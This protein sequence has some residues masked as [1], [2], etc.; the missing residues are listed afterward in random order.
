[1]DSQYHW[2]HGGTFKMAWGE[3]LLIDDAPGE[4]TVLS[5]SVWLTRSADAQDHRLRAGDR[6]VVSTTDS[7]VFE[8]WDRREPAVV[9]WQPRASAARPQWR[10]ALAALLRGFAA[11]A[12]G[13]AAGL[14]RAEAGFEALARNAASTASRAQ[15]CMRLGESMASPG[16]V[17]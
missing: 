3:P 15:G 16:A 8:A 14:R 1:M 6:L 9:A 4:L 17:K 12:G 2:Y 7:V 5:G 13:V 11:A 10:L